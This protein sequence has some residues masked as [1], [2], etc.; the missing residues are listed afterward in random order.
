MDTN[1]YLRSSIFDFNPIDINGSCE[2][3]YKQDNA[4]NVMEIFMKNKM[5]ICVI[6]GRWTEVILRKKMWSFWFFQ[7]GVSGLIFSLLSVSYLEFECL[8]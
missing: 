6:Q 1:I 8:R 7:R 4:I 3:T 5:V 2:C